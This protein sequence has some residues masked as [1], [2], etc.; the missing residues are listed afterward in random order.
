M[1]LTWILALAPL[2][3]SACVTTTTRS[4][5]WGDPYAGQPQSWERRGRVDYVRETVEAQRGD[6]A[7]GAVAGA[8][9]GGILGHALV[10]RGG[11][12][13]GAIG[14]AAVGASASQGYSERR[15]YEVFVRYEDGGTER[16]VYE[17]AP[18]FRVGAGVVLTPQGLYPE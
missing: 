12:L 4:S 2:A 13:I 1:R 11:G 10:G 9:V 14:G 5:G 17:G 16:Y 15:F 6:P 8:V 7:G 18:P 3:L